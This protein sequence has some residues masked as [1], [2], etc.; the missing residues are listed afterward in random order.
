MKKSLPRRRTE[1]R[2]RARQKILAAAT[3]L[4]AE[5]GL[6]DVTYGDIAKDSGLSRPLVYFYFPNQE[7]LIQETFLTACQRLQERFVA[8][9]SKASNGSESLMA[10]GRA[11]LQFHDDCPEEARLML[12][13][14]AHCPPITDTT[15]SVDK[16]HKSVASQADAKGADASD[17][18]SVT[19]R[20]LEQK[21]A[22]IA[23]V[24]SQVER[25]RRDGSVRKEGAS[26]TV[27]ALNLWAFTHGL[28]GLRG[29]LGDTLDGIYGV[30]MTE[31]LDHGFQLIDNALAPQKVVR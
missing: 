12:L 18:S 23:L 27:I 13:E 19:A 16:A 10:I 15:S 11:Y 6:E 3:H 5:R 4:F 25:G 9:V 2:E 20:L 14:G 21:W 22:I 28:V 31:F 1:D 29:Q 30:S 7:S 8:A 17:G 24:A 26:A